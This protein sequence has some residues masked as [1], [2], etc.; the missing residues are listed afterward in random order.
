MLRRTQI[1]GSAAIQ[2]TRAGR[3]RIGF[4]KATHVRFVFYRREQ[5][6]GSAQRL[7]QKEALQFPLS[8]DVENTPGESPRIGRL[9]LEVLVGLGLRLIM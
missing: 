5:G 3:T 6:H 4:I 8:L 1:D 9:L 2:V 7:V